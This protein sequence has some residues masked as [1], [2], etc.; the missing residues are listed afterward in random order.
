MDSL[1]ILRV[2]ILWSCIFILANYC[3]CSGAIITSFLVKM[4]DHSVFYLQR[5]RVDLRSPAESRLRAGSLQGG[6]C[7]LQVSARPGSRRVWFAGRRL[8]E[9][10]KKKEWIWGSTLTLSGWEG[11]RS[12]VCICVSMCRGVAGGV[13]GNIYSFFVLIVSFNESSNSYVNTAS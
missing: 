4:S 2:F 7:A 8:A 5:I 11:S 9:K 12:G 1:E 6:R 10:K 3:H 13:V